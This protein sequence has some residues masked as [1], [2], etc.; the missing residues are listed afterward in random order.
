[1]LSIAEKT[2]RLG[3]KEGWGDLGADAGG[4]VGWGI[5]VTLI[6]D[7]GVAL[8]EQPYRRTFPPA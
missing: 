2:P 7:D 1:M 4:V 8:R 3:L 6:R 5:T